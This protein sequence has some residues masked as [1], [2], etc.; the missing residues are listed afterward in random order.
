MSDIRKLIGTRPMFMPAA[1][2][3]LYHEGQILLQ[4]RADNGLWALH[5]G[6]MEMGETTEETA[7]REAREEIGIVPE[8]LTFY[9]VFSGPEM[10]H[11]YPDGN[12][13]HIVSTVYFCDAYKATL[14]IDAEEVS[15]IQWFDVHHLP[16]TLAPIDRFILRGLHPFLKN[17]GL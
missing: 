5:G 14:Q 12:E 15:A 7:I 4:K 6:A 9:G 10:Y 11:V 1:G 2:I 3:I 8:S 17:R 13:V 16:E